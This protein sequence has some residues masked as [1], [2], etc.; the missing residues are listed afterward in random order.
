MPRRR[1]LQYNT[2]T[3]YIYTT[4]KPLILMLAKRRNRLSRIPGLIAP[5]IA[6]CGDPPQVAQA[7]HGMAMA[8]GT[9]VIQCIQ[10]QGLYNAQAEP[11]SQ[12]DRRHSTS[13]TQSWTSNAIQSPGVKNHVYSNGALWN[14]NKGVFSIAW[15]SHSQHPLYRVLLP[16]HWRDKP[17]LQRTFCSQVIMS[18]RV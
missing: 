9:Q 1:C 17:T 13:E 3:F 12:R 18:P 2:L 8:N 7:C 6:K 11:P 14:E 15:Q 4:F 10:E 16:R 5:G